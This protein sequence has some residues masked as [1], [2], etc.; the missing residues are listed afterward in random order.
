MK[1]TAPL[2]LRRGNVLLN[3]ATR[4]ISVKS[5][6]GVITYQKYFFGF[7]NNFISPKFPLSVH[8]LKLKLTNYALGLSISSMK[9]HKIYLPF[10]LCYMVVIYQYISHQ[11]SH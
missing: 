2:T 4:G 6:S 9:P 10:I 5:S 3:C 1:F 7:A 11:K 8:L